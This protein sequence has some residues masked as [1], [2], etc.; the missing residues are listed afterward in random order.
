VATPAS[1]AQKAELESDPVSQPA[2]RK[3][4]NFL[5]DWRA[6]PA[7]S[8]AGRADRPTPASRS[9]CWAESAEVD[10]PAEGGCPQ[11]ARESAELDEPAEGG[12]PQG[13]RESTGADG[14]QRAGRSAGRS[15]SRESPGQFV[16]RRA[17]E[18]S[19]FG[20]PT[21]ECEEPVWRARAPWPQKQ[22]PVGL[23]WDQRVWLRGQDC[24]VCWRLGPRSPSRVFKSCSAQQVPRAQRG[25]R[26]QRRLNEQL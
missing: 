4:H 7:P 11:G 1:S 13:A 17:S 24:P 16:K 8:S 20:G 26:R 19:L 14:V 9:A 5:T 25:Q 6:K 18:A 2:A 10:E 23:R 12:C 21:M 3:L 15:A 22:K